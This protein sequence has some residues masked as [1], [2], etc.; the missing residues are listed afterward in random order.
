MNELTLEQ[1]ISLATK[2]AHIVMSAHANKQCLKREI[3]A[4]DILETLLKG[5]II[6]QYPTDFP[7]PSCLMLGFTSK[8][9]PMHVCCAIGDNKLWIITAYYPTEEKWESD[10]KTRKAVK[11]NDLFIL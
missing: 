5:S 3:N 2:T 1:I 11:N 8:H 10:Y 6:E 9:K 7:F 4:E